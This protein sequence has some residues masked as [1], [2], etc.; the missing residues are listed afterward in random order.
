LEVDETT[1]TEINWH[2]WGEEAFRK[3]R[4]LK[5][6]VLMDITAVWCHWCHVMD[7]T[8]YSD[9]GVIRLANSL[10]IPIRVDTDQRPDINRRYN[11]GGWPT[12]LFL[13]P[14]GDVITGATYVP[15]NQMRILMRQVSEQYSR[16][17]KKIQQKRIV[18]EPE[19]ESELR[20]PTRL[21]PEASELIVNEVVGMMLSAFDNLYGGFG[22]QPKF[23]QPD[24]ISLALEQYNLNK[25]RG[26]YLLIM[27]TL[28]NMAS[29]GMYDKDKG[30]FFRYATR[31]DWS[32]PHYEKILE[33]NA[34]LLT[35]Y[36]DAYR[37]LEIESHEGVGQK[38]IS[39][40]ESTLS[41]KKIGGFYSSQDADEEYY[42]C[43]PSERE[44]RTPPKVDTNIYVGSNAL[45]ASAYLL[46]SVTLQRPDL[47]TFAI[48]TIHYLDEK[49]RSKSGMM[50]HIHSRDGPKP[51]YLLID[52]VHMAQTLLEA[53][54]YSS[55]KSYLEKAEDLTKLILDRFHDVKAGGFYDILLEQDS[56]GAL[57][58]REKPIDENSEATELLVKL[59]DLTGREDYVEK[60]K[61]T[62]GVFEETYRGYGIVASSY[63]RVVHKLAAP[64]TTITV[65]GR[66][67]NP[68]TAIL[69]DQSL[70]FYVARKS[71]QVLD[72]SVDNDKIS[73][74]GFQI[75]DVPTAYPCVGHVC[76]EPI[77]NPE[78]LASKLSKTVV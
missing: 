43:S 38:I 13:T 59:Y 62:L 5:R 46:A 14:D 6:P 67:D 74:L 1:E 48:K 49:C 9:R 2:Q 50:Y 78:E 26:L 64:P 44:K 37:I 40:V 34:K 27:K 3:A 45:M 68:V 18:E 41:N 76:L 47:Q 66:K 53:Y 21:E 51:P 4:E 17:W 28:D 11:I 77:T 75:S 36:L 20:I 69:R 58:V 15:P 56:I 60:A 55:E 39:Y 71:V 10:F 25:D 30:G 61:E 29:G 22:D 65:I 57:R 24:A 16:S 12:T 19:S 72:P 33:D 8:S 63:A 70:R 52:Q 42:Q 35:I 32:V 73:V 54:M 31:R 23:P 7:Q